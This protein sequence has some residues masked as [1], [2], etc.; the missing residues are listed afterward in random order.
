MKNRQLGFLTIAL[1]MGWSMT[2]C[3]AAEVRPGENDIQ[4]R[5]E[6]DSHLSLSPPAERIWEGAVGEGLRRGTHE[7]GFSLGAGFGMRIIGSTETHDLALATLRYGW[8]FSDVVGRD[9][10]YR[11]NWEL[12]GEAFGGAQFHPHGAYVA[13]AL[14]LIRYDF[15]TGSRWVPFVNAGAGVA[16]TDIRGKDLS[17]TFEFTLQAGGG[18]NYFWRDN[19]AVTFQ[20]R[21]LHLSNAGIK[22]PNLG[23]NTSMFCVGM[24]WFF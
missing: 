13:G 18:V 14:P 24:S 2:S 3:M 19:A 9:H 16:A 15:A 17:T 4:P 8:V 6:L 10:W 1:V 23:V 7:A 5:L 11:G 20:Y 12:L 22:D 21:F